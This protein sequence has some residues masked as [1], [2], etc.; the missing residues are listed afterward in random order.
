[1][2]YPRD[3]LFPRNVTLHQCVSLKEFCL[4]IMISSSMNISV[5]CVNVSVNS[6][7]QVSNGAVTIILL[8]AGGGQDGSVFIT[9]IT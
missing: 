7:Q 5:V 3:Y 1:M 2:E 9:T 4:Y 8:S 6:F